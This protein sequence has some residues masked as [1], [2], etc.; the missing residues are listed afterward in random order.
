ME[1]EEPRGRRKRSGSE[2]RKRSL[3]PFPL[4]LGPEERAAIEAAADEAGLSMGG[5]IRSAALTAPTT[6]ARR[7]PSVD[8]LA[9][10][11]LLGQVNKIGGNLHQL[12]RHL[13]FG[14]TLEA[15]EV[16]AAL[17]GY[18]EVVAAIMTALGRQP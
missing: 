13:N 2:K 7:R 6:R 15:G 11:R 9:I 3:P 10:T 8:L 16:R 1:P 18:D 17:R 12:V 14:G 5:Y 4:R